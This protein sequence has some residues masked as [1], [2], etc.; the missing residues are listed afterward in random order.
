MRSIAN[1]RGPKGN[2]TSD[3]PPSLSLMMLISLL[4]PVFV[5]A[6][7]GALLAK[8]PW[9]R[10]GWQAGVADLTAKVLLPALLLGSTYR[11][12]IPSS[13]SWQV[14]GAFYIPLA[15]LFLVMR[16]GMGR[17]AGAAARALAATYSNTVFVGLP[18]LVHTLG[19]E[20][21]Q[22]AVPV[23]AFH[24]LIC[25]T[26][27]HL[28]DAESGGGWRASFANALTNPIVASLLAGL[29]LNLAGVALPSALIALLDMLSA[30][31]LPCA[32]LVLGASIATMKTQG[33]RGAG[34]I[35]LAKLVLLPLSVFALG[36]FAF[37]LPRPTWAVLVVLASCPVGLNAAFVVKADSEHAQLV[38]SSI[39]LSSLTCAA[40]IPI[41]L[42]SLSWQS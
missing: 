13:V 32:L 9:L 12:G 11:T 31:A 28:T 16:F 14:L 39:F 38:H 5:A 25:F 20:S 8:L 42:W 18:V 24:S 33:W 4:A 2:P 40:T 23:I 22:F 26:L 30:A 36:V 29:A 7:F 1:L 10:P 34:A 27:Y 3:T 37:G 6:G 17:S 15:A 35:V 41:W 19:R 21:L